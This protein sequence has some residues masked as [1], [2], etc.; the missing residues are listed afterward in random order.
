MTW[1]IDSGAT[2]HMTSMKQLLSSYS[3]FK[4]INSVKIADGSHLPVE[5]QGLIPATTTVSLHSNLHVP[6]MLII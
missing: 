1:V 3:K 5:G 2:E 4:S 6:R